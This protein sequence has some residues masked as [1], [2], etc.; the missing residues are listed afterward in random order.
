MALPIYSMQIIKEITDSIKLN[1]PNKRY[2]MISLGY[3]DI[4]ANKDTLN[5]IFGYDVCQNVKYHSDSAS[6]IKWHNASDIT[7]GI[8]NADEV[9]NELGFDLDII[10]IVKARGDERI[11]DLNTPLPDDLKEQY[12][13]LIDA[14]TIEHCFNIAQAIKNISEMVNVGG[15]I[16][17]INPL[18]LVN[19]GFYNLNPTFYYDFYLENGFEVVFNE[20]IIDQARDPKTFTLHHFKRFNDIPNEACNLVVAQ[21]KERKDIVWPT[22]YKYKVNSHLKG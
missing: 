8:P 13:L 20:G 11:V 5:R 21:R 6:I 3:P 4:I 15:Y 19:H 9:F 2:R 18:S 16:F 12:D 17:H 10:D 14:G 22:Q 7:E 1:D